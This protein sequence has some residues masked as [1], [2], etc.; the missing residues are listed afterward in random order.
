MRTPVAAAILLC[1]APSAALAQ[2]GSIVLES[3]A[4]E[5]PRDAD[6]LL[7]PLFRE[8][9]TKGFLA[10]NDVAQLIE[11]KV[12]RAGDPLDPAQLAEATR[13]IDHGYGSFLK[14]QFEVATTELGRALEMLRSRPATL[15][16]N[17]PLRD[18]ALRAH[19]GLALAHQRLGH[20][21]D[22]TAVM[23]EFARSFP[24]REISRA[25]YGPEPA[26]LAKKVRAE[27]DQRGRG[28]LK[29]KV[30]DATAVIF[31]NERYLG[32]GEASVLDL[33]AGKYR[34]YVQR[35]TSAGRVHEVDVVPGSEQTVK[36]SWAL[37]AAL[38]TAPF[39]GLSFEGEAA[40]DE[41]ALASN[42]ALALDAPR[43]VVISIRE[44]DK[45]RS[46]WGAVLDPASG[47]SS[48]SGALAL[49]PVKPGPDKIR[50]LGRYL[51]G[52]EASPDI[53]IEP[54][55]DTGPEPK[56]D[57]KVIDK[58]RPG[59]GSDGGS[60]SRPFKVLKWVTLIVGVGALGA[61]AYLIA[62]DGKSSCDAPGCADEYD[63]AVPGY[64]SA[65][66]GAALI[67]AGIV[68]FIKD[69]GAKKRESQVSFAPARGGMVFT[70]GRTF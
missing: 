43:V 62:I 1:L 52:G 36:I 38:K 11:A 60:V 25:Q 19:L 15:S 39:T 64:V 65:G 58:F 35:G 42:L 68:F 66:A 63:T 29:I 14:G 32:V 22:A 34:I 41:A 3:Y 69:S 47:K 12:S 13:L 37:D 70:F 20:A 8:L 4:G 18:Q 44:F 33:Y 67:G 51:T 56:A 50:E 5:R 40:R 21:E 17:Q 45:R 10:G 55:F 30:D 54:N 2:R 27:L 31:L 59:S 61:G 53:I 6:E 23:A 7:T 57:P 9:A 46:L 16:K 28:A 24:D 26:E 49:E 48:R